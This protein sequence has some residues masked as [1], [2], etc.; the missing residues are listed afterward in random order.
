MGFPSAVTENCPKNLNS[1]TNLVKR[2][3][4]P[5]KYGKCTYFTLASVKKIRWMNDRTY[6]Q[7]TVDSYYG[8]NK[9]NKQ[10]G[11]KGDNKMN[12][13]ELEMIANE[14][15]ERMI[16]EADKERIGRK[17]T[18]LTEVFDWRNLSLGAVLTL[19]G[20]LVVFL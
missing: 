3:I 16:Q 19:V 20:W 11:L 13:F 10:P 14:K 17:T 1:S 2:V 4:N 8:C 6:A 5:R 18:G 9:E 15:H 12:T 7:G